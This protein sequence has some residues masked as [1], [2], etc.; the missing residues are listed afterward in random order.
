[1]TK[2]KSECALDSAIEMHAQN[3]IEAGRISYELPT[4]LMDTFA[5]WSNLTPDCELSHWEALKASR[6]ELFK[7]IKQLEANAHA[8]A[9]SWWNVT[10]CIE[11]AR[12]KECKAV[13]SKAAK[14]RTHSAFAMLDEVSAKIADSYSD[15]VSDFLAAVLEAN[16]FK[17]CVRKPGSLIHASYNQMLPY[18]LEPTLYRYNLYYD[19]LRMSTGKYS[20]L[21]RLEN[22]SGLLGLAR[23]YVN[24]PGNKLC[25]CVNNLGEEAVKIL[26]IKPDKKKRQYIELKNKNSIKWGVKLIAEAY[27]HV[28][29][30]IARA[31]E[32]SL[33][34]S[35]E[36]RHELPARFNGKSVAL[37]NSL[38][39]LAK[40]LITAA[41][42]ANT[43]KDYIDSGKC[44]VQTKW[45]GVVSSEVDPQIVDVGA[46]K[47]LSIMNGASNWLMRLT[48]TSARYGP[49][50]FV[51]NL[52]KKRQR[53]LQNGKLN[54]DGM[55]PF[56][57]LSEKDIEVAMPLIKEA[58]DYIFRNV[59]I[60]GV[61]VSL[62]EDQV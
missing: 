31:P 25:E 5:A 23:V 4:A 52:P 17:D 51:L 46:Y 7:L 50:R 48:S 38:D 40:K 27:A 44:L 18:D 35:L 2:T 45:A 43:Y 6:D 10:S 39:A 37:F 28:F 56:A 9:K 55:V 60:D 41:L 61:S 53:E 8:A 19:T 32:N 13:K 16:P 26:K 1:M 29:R 33:A 34:T 58:Y 49:V 21:I 59:F 47:L 36:L 42:E 22:T 24:L 20:W 62:E 54:R 11:Q 15:L 14:K 12:S 3:M 30:G 57:L